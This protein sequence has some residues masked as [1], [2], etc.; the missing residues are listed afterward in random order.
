MSIATSEIRPLTASAFRT[1]EKFTEFCRNGGRPLGGIIA[2]EPVPGSMNVTF[3]TVDPG[4][5]EVLATV[6]EMGEAEVA[7]AV[8]AAQRAFD[9]H[10]GKSWRNTDVEERIRLVNRLVELCDRDRDVLLACEIRDGG[11]VSELAEGDFTQIRACAEYFSGVARRIE[12]GDGP[13]M[14]VA[15]GV[16]GFTYREPWGVV[17]GIVP[18][19][20]PIVLTSWFMF[21]AL[22]SGNTILIKPAEDTPLSALYIA[23]LAQEAGFPPGV[24]NVLPGRGEITGHCIAEHPGVRYISFTGSPGVGQAILRTCD[25]HGTRMKRE[26]GGNGAAIV[27]ADAD[28]ELVAHR[29]AVYQPALWPDLL[30]DSSRVRRQED[31]RRLHRC[32]DQVL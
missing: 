11:K 26:L 20:Y 29:G 13:S 25:R 8:A 22:L 15:A 1:P 6:C 21:P 31:C 12:M 14:N 3:Q 18:W 28:P 5:Q 24:I 30:H 2:G 32:P 9:G 10:G 16:R 17:A 27:L 23:K 4:S 7:R 19:N